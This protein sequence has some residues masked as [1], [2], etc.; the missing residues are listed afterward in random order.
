MIDH[1]GI[2]YLDSD[3]IYYYYCHAD[4][5]EIEKYR[6]NWYKVVCVIEFKNISDHMNTYFVPQTKLE[7]FLK[8]NPERLLDII[9]TSL[10][11]IKETLGKYD[12]HI[13]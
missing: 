10:A 4:K 11:E 12:I 7:E 13:E 9:P 1:E 5:N 6:N 2:S 8:S 3:D